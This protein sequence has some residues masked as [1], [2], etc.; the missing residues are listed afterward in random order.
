MAKSWAL[1]EILE[2]FFLNYL[3]VTG[4]ISLARPFSSSNVTEYS[5][6]KNI[7]SLLGTKERP[8][9]QKQNNSAV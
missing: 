8:L 4:F 5:Q 7:L 2:S 6:S 1:P 9:L 3:S